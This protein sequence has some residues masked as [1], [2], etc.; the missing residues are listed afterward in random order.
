MVSGL[1][2]NDLEFVLV[3]RWFPVLCQQE[4]SERADEGVLLLVLC[5]KTRMKADDS[6]SL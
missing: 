1:G 3:G 5:R 2:L 6:C 4:I